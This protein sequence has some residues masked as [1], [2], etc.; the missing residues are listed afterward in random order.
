MKILSIVII[1]SILLSGSILGQDSIYLKG[2]GW[3]RIDLIIAQTPE[4][5]FIDKSLSLLDEYIKTIDRDNRKQFIKDSI[6]YFNCPA[7]KLWESKGYLSSREDTWAVRYLDN[8][9]N[10]KPK[11]PN[12][13]GFIKYLRKKMK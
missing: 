8:L 6:E 11:Q 13:T 5:I 4:R 2:D 10:K 3:T 7:H 9:I 12:V 1:I